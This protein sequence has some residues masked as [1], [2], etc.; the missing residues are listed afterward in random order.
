MMGL[1]VAPT[2]AAI[3]DALALINAVLDPQTAKAGLEALRAAIAE[4]EQA[5]AAAIEEQKKAA[6]ATA[7]AEKATAALADARAA[8]VQ[9]EAT[10]SARELQADRIRALTRERLAGMEA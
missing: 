4:H 2:P 5:R 3:S 7:E 8:L 9:R 6:T 1:S 10:V